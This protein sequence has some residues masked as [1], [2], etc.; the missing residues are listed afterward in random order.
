MDCALNIV[1]NEKYTADKLQLHE[2]CFEYILIEESFSIYIHIYL[3]SFR[4]EWEMPVQ[5]TYRER[6]RERES[7]LESRVRVC[8]ERKNTSGGIGGD[9]GGERCASSKT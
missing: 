5:S 1:E 4:L 2:L 6:E 3:N 7:G 9:D 8:N